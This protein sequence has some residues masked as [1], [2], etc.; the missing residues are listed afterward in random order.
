MVYS[1]ISPDSLPSS[2]AF[3]QGSVLLL[4]R[5]T[6]VFLTPRVNVSVK[7]DENSSKE[8]KAHEKH[9]WF[10][11]SREKASLRRGSPSEELLS[12]SVLASQDADGGFLT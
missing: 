2:W 12:R 5:E 8:N 11:S 6:L 1:I 4:L 7:E 3:Q 10:N 9:A